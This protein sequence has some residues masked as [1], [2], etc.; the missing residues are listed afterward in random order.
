M[1]YT[2]TPLSFLLL[3]VLF[4]AY[5]A[6]KANWSSLRIEV[7]IA[8]ALVVMSGFVLD[9]AINWTFGL[10]LGAT[11]DVTLSQ[12]CKRVGKGMGWQA[13]TARYLCTNWLSPFE[14]DH[15]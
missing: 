7:K 11:K 12:K 2:F 5:T 6:L 15:C 9:V 8:G 14:M 13:S 10:I 3:W 4:L 1:I